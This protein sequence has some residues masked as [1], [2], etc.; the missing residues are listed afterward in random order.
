M[1]SKVFILQLLLTF[2]IASGWIYI[3]VLAGLRF[4]SKTGGFIGGLPSTALLSFFFIGFT[5]SPEIASSDTTIFPVAIAISGL[6]LIVFASIAHKGFL[7]A[8]LSS[9]GFWFLVSGIISL[10]RLDNFLINLIIYFAVML[11]AYLIL[12]KYLMIK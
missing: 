12:E 1:I 8:I 2:L 4:G 9:L 5:Q 3:T 7:L 6:F 10:F 11:F